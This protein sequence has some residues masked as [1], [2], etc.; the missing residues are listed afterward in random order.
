[1]LIKLDCMNDE[2]FPNF[3]GGEKEITARIYQDDNVEILWA[4]L[5]PGASVGMHT[6]KT[7][8]ETMFFVSGTGK[9]IIGG[10]TEPVRAGVAH[11]CPK[12]HT[13]ALINDG[14]EDL[15]FYAVL[16]TLK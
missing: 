6:H 5:A 7:E 4:K 16:P 12:G 13:H 8:S 3:L 10:Q 14:N 9:A 11:Y 2:V 1:M 15:V